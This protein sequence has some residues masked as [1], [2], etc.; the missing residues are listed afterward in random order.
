[1][2]S[3]ARASDEFVDVVCADEELVRA[4]FDALMRECWPDDPPGSAPHPSA[5]HPPGT[6]RPES[7]GWVPAGAGAP[8]ADRSGSER[9]PP[10]G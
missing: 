4:E 8:A 5:P 2:M 7:P 3:T 9:A 6:A 10:R 1:M